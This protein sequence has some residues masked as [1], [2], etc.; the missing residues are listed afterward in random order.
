[1][2]SKNNLS[3]NFK[4]A[5][6]LSAVICSFALAACGSG[7]G[8]S[9]GGMKGS[10][11]SSSSSSSNST[12]SSSSSSG[13]TGSS[14]T[15]SS[16]NSSS[17]TSN[18]SSSSSSTSSTG[19]PVLTPEPNA[20]HI[21]AFPEQTRA[22][23]QRSSFSVA[24]KVVTSS[25]KSPWGITHLADGRMLITEKA[26]NL[27]IVTPDGKISA[28]IQGVPAVDARGQGGLLDVVLSPDF[29]TNRKIFISYAKEVSKSNYTTAIGSGEFDGKTIKNFKEFFVA[30]GANNNGEHFGGRVVVDSDSSIWLSVGERGERDNAQNLENH[31]GKILRINSE[32]KPH[33]ENPFVGKTKGLPEI[34]S[35]GHRNPQGLVR[36]TLTRELWES[37]HG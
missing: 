13:L 7:N 25:L 2:A 19:Q 28:P 11:S 10:S 8:S 31:L 17:S 5:Q 29:K 27:V 33:P 16:S 12:T 37:E 23:E 15:S 4:P 35:Y 3:M 9:S 32:G 6:L 22:P 36:N 21:R 26:G 24:A 1:M 20:Q 30:T 14:S 34:Y 18:S